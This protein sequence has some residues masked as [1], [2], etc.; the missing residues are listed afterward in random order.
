[1]TKERQRL[2]QSTLLLEFQIG[3]SGEVTG[4]KEASKEAA[5][6]IQEVRK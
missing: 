3:S 5:E 6:V 1:M 2:G 4:E